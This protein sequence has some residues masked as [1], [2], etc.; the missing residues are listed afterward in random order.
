MKLLG[1]TFTGVDSTID[2][3]ELKKIQDNFPWVEWGILLSDFYMGTQLRFPGE[4]WLAGLR[5]FATQ[6]E[7]NLSGHYCG[8]W[9]RD[10]IKGLKSPFTKE[11]FN[12]DI[13]KRIQLNTKIDKLP[14][15]DIVGLAN[16]IKSMDQEFIF[17]CN[18]GL[19]DAVVLLL[20]RSGI[21]VSGLF[22]RSG[23][24]GLVPD[25]WPEPYKNIKMGYAGG[26]NPINLSLELEKISE[27]VGEGT[28][29]IDM[30]T[31]IRTD[32]KFDLKKV[33]LCLET[34]AP[35]IQ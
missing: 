27:I 28:I 34:A 1:V 26:L 20:N 6:N 24:H 4:G 35:W 32:D 11:G 21:N 25:N 18:G 17:Q 8:R 9:A 19:N 31:G 3:S 15:L 7:L 23:G 16:T 30:E 13:F 5:S 2:L 14:V 10:V 12:P 33:S 29:W 22:D